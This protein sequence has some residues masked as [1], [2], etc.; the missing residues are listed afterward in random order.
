MKSFVSRA[1]LIRAAVISDELLDSFAQRLGYVIRPDDDLDEEDQSMIVPGRGT[2]THEGQI[3]SETVSRRKKNTRETYQPSPIT[4]WCHT[5]TRVFEL[6]DNERVGPPVP[7][8]TGDPWRSRPKEVGLNE[9]LASNTTLRTNLRKRLTQRRPTG[10]VDIGRTIDIFCRGEFVNRLPRYPQRRWGNSLV[11]IVDRSR[12]LFPY[13]EQYQQVIALLDTIYSE[14]N[15]QL[16]YIFDSSR[17]PKWSDRSQPNQFVFP[18][19][20]QVLCLTDLGLL[21]KGQRNVSSAWRRT[22]RLAHSSGC[23][24]TVLFPGHVRWCSDRIRR[25]WN[26]MPWSGSSRGI[27]SA[28]SVNALTDRLISLCSPAIRIEP[29]LLRSVRRRT[30]GAC[31]DAALESLVWQHDSVDGTSST[32]AQIHPTIRQRFLKNRERGTLADTVLQS[33]RQ[34]H[35]ALHAAVWFEELVSLFGHDTPL[36]ESS[37]RKDALRYLGSFS[38]KLQTDIA[39]NGLNTDAA[40]W[41]RAFSGRLPNDCRNDSDLVKVLD[42]LLEQA[43]PRKEGETAS[44]TEVFS[45]QRVTDRWSVV[46]TSEPGAAVLATIRTSNR[47][48]GFTAVD[49][50]LLPDPFWADGRA[51]DWA[52]DWGRD[53]F[54]AWVEFSV[55]GSKENDAAE[56]VTVRMRW[57]PAGKFLMGSPEGEEGRD[58]D[59]GPQHDV[60]ISQGFWMFDAPVTQALWTAVMGENPSEFGGADRPV[61]TVSWNDSQKFT[62]ADE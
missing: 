39:R 19:G 34:S 36:L 27:W 60:T 28:D 47:S 11:V 14:E 40:V 58:D 31:F 5:H 54:G 52:S 22:G 1:D 10:D 55:P 6:G 48:V 51:P 24:T 17:L 33:I 4:L 7:M 45:I 18:A 50:S 29:D 30:P 37:D 16:A 23:R 8:I 21:R 42:P 56:T 38:G 61:E 53:E 25:T 26:V 12:H 3:Q 13:F 46:R 32:A 62:E 2:V 20:A 57:V 35:S 9:P 41:V 59:E 49:E 43:F 44:G 15:V